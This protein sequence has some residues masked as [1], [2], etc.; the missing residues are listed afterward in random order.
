MHRFIPATDAAPASEIDPT[1][2]AAIKRWTREILGLGQDDVITVTEI[3]CVDAG[4][5]LVETVVAV[6]G[7]GGARTWRFTRPRVAVTKMMVQQ[8][9]GR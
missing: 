9:I 6:F 8:A 5:P 7:A 2:T 4:C 1:H 3:A